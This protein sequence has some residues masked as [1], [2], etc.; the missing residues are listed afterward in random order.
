MT[1]KPKSKPA[2]TGKTDEL[3]D[4]ALDKV[5]G[6][7]HFGAQGGDPVGAVVLRPPEVKPS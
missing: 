5:A 6:G 1:L 3:P 4:A 2:V 7:G